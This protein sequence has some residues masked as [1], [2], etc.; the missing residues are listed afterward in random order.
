MTKLD[1]EIL[2]VIIFLSIGEIIIGG[3]ITFVIMMW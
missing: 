1:K 2:S 3:L